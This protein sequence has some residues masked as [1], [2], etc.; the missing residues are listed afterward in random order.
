MLTL[1]AH[2]HKIW[3]PRRSFC[4]TLKDESH[5]A[6]GLSLSYDMDIH[7]HPHRY[8]YTYLQIEIR[9]V[10]TVLKY[11]YSFINICMHE[12]TP[13]TYWYFLQ[14][15]D[16]IA[17]YYTHIYP[18]IQID[19]FVFC[20][21]CHL[22]THKKGYILYDHKSEYVDYNPFTCMQ[23]QLSVRVCACVCVQGFVFGLRR[24]GGCYGIY[25]AVARTLPLNILTE[26]F[27]WPA[28]MMQ[29]SLTPVLSW[30]PIETCPSAFPPFSLPSHSFL[31]HS[32]SQTPSP[33]SLSGFCLL[34]IPSFHLS[35]HR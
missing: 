4:S 24:N 35:L 32:L 26:P 29:D 20:Y 25:S 9:C 31:C 19:M 16:G 7:D 13:S 8:A 33:F 30:A 6:G 3:F 21:F 14:S 5:T 22:S 10:F 1:V 28:T 17:E 12:N 34:S 18:E 15:D 2:R 27:H 23:K 11:V